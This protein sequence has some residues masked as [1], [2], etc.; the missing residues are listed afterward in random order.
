ML[1]AGIVGLPNVGKSTLFNALTNAQVEAANY[2]FATI[3]PNVAIVPVRD[4]RLIA[5]ANLIQPDQLTFATFRFVDI[6]GLVKGAAQ[7]EGLGNKFLANIREVDC[8]VHVVRCFDDHKITHVANKVDPVADVEIIDYELAAADLETI[9][10]RIS[11][12]VRKANSGDA[13]AVAELTACQKIQAA[14]QQGKAART[15]AL[16]DDEK[17]LAKP[18]N[19][20][21][22]KPVVYVANVAESDVANPTA[23]AR[24]LELQSALSKDAVLIPVSAQIESELA[25]ASSDEERAEMQ[26]AFGL[27]NTSGLDAITRAA[28]RALRM[29][30][31]F[32]F[33]KKETRAWTFREGAKAPECAGIIHTDFAR[34]F[35][36]A[37]VIDWQE[38]VACG[39][40]TKARAEGKMRLEG[41]DYVMRDGDV[42]KFRFNV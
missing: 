14:L 40:E 12:V 11:R 8:I 15:V 37:E 19:L 23:C 29:Q 1:A 3:E 30:T 26:A 20:L 21:T 25:Q 5:L 2:P 32:T 39:S 27:A 10:G 34:G 16:T 42:C 41:K 24:Y 31:Y 9:N 13:Q 18:F 17:E 35:I 4:P 28:Y 36:R 7:G 22:L 6:A 38:L 33:G